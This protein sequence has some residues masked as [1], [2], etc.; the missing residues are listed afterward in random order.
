MA[1]RMAWRDYGLADIVDALES[2]SLEDDDVF[3]SSTSSTYCLSGIQG[4]Y[5]LIG[6]AREHFVSSNTIKPDHLVP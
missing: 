4:Q 2:L 1:K 5:V 6:A 3:G